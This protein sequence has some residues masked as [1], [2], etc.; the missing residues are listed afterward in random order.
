MGT[1]NH[2]VEI[3]YRVR[4]LR[5]GNFPWRKRNSIRSAKLHVAQ[6]DA[7]D[8]VTRSKSL[9]L[10]AATKGSFDTQSFRPV[11]QKNLKRFHRERLFYK[12]EKKEK[13]QP[14]KAPFVFVNRYLEMDFKNVPSF[15]FF[16]NETHLQGFYPD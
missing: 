5:K 13:M 7:H 12:K 14:A 6:M 2:Q 4:R 8:R 3:K 16:E 10:L 11:I 1:R 15:F 9:S